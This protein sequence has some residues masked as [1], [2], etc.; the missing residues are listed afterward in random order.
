MT[1]VVA[2][3]TPTPTRTPTPVPPT[4]TRTL[5]AT[6]TRTPTPMLP[7]NTP[8]RTPTPVVPQI[9]INAT[10]ALQG[11]NRTGA[12][13]NI[14]LTISIKNSTLRWNT[15][16]VNGALSN[17]PLPSLIAGTHT[18]IFEP[19]GYLAR[20]K[21]QAVVTGLNTIVLNTITF[22][23]G[24]IDGSGEVNAL[25]YVVLLSKFKTND[26]QTDLDGSGQVNS[27]D[28]SLMIGNWKETTTST[29]CLLL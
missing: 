26:A 19:A 1:V 9:N 5:T 13:K 21:Q 6:P 7:T 22:C 12:N 4:P 11:R 18:F 25:D 2:S 20:E 24:D 3:S 27:L 10:F 17:F 28:F 16:T 14:P 23:A 8:T 29:T 15:T